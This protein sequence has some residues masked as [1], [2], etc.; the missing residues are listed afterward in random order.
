MK[1]YFYLYLPTRFH[2]DLVVKTGIGLGESRVIIQILNEQY[3]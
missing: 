2:A 3:V 1:L